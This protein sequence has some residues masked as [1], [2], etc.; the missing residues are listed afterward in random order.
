MTSA[1]LLAQAERSEGLGSGIAAALYRST[2]QRGL[3]E[4]ESLGINAGT[5]ARWRAALR[6][7]LP[8]LGTR[9]GEDASVGHRI[10][11]A[12]LRSADGLEFECVHLPMGSQKS[13]LCISTQVGCRQ[14]CTFC[15]TARMGL[16]RN[17]GPEEIVG[18]VVVA[19]AQ[20]GWQ[21]QTIVYQGMGE[22]LDNSEA[23]IQSLKVLTDP[24]GL[25]YGHDRITICTA[26]RVE[27]IHK[28]AELGWKRLNLS[29]SLNAS[30]DETRREIM[31]SHRDTSLAELQAVLIAFRQRRNLQLGIHYCL[32]PGINDGRDDAVR[33][34][35]FCAPLGRCMIHLIPYNPGLSPL[36]RAPEDHEVE[37]F[38]GWLRE[39]G[40]MV[41]RRITKGRSVM[42]ACGQLGNRDL[43]RKIL[44][45]P[46][47]A[48]SS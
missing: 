6:F 36:C 34:A 8:L 46:Q 16:L 20:L 3:F 7:D 18:Q 39:Q 35:T 9:A 10:E 37:R 47:Q 48:S 21:P 1:E 17:L 5:A 12:V 26:G 33:I 44:S 13:S 27:G 29:L 30:N 15:E 40:L 19:R 23:V 24:R 45:N 38:V 25:A 11:K 31:P 2:H 41:R 4:P 42:A 43:R 32:M 22:P 28:L 14:A